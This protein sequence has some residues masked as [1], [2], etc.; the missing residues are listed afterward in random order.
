MSFTFSPGSLGDTSADVKWENA[1]PEAF[2]ER[3]RIGL[4]VTRQKWDAL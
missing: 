4:G 1:S 2:N 3:K